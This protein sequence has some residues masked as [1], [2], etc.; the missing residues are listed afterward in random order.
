MMNIFIYIIII[1]IIIICLGVYVYIYILLLL[2]LLLLL[3]FISIP[4]APLLL[5]KNY[6]RILR[7]LRDQDQLRPLERGYLS[8]LK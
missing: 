3:L 2:L 8:A 6:T 7:A 4:C 5:Q 1:I